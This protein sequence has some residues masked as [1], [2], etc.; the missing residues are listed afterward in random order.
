MVARYGPGALIDKFDVEA[1][2]QNIAIHPEDG[3]MLNMK[4]QRQLYVDLALLFGL[5]SAPFMIW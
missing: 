1:A 4:W 3:C 5:R 2:Y